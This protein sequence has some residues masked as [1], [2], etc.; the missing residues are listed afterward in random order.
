MTRGNILL[1]TILWSIIA[2]IVL[3]PL[4]ILLVESFKIAG[5]E[6]WGISNYLEF[7]KDTYYLKTFGTKTT[8]HLN[9]IFK[10]FSTDFG[11]DEKQIIK[12]IIPFSNDVNFIINKYNYLFNNQL[13][14]VRKR[15]K[16][17][18]EVVFIPTTEYRFK[19][20]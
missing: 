5:T 1:S 3:F 17:D 12:F 13:G 4:S 11:K 10:W 18:I 14:T 16:L 6:S 19:L 7:F 9:R 8:I 15:D 2:F 20:K